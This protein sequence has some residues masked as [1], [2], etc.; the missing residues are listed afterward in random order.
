[1][2]TGRIHM[3]AIRTSILLIILAVGCF[4]GSSLLAEEP[5]L[6]ISADDDGLAWGTCPDFMPDG[7]AIAVLHGDPGAANADVF[8]KV[9]G[10]SQ[11]PLHRHTSAERMVLVSGQMNVT[12]E[13]QDAVTIRAGDYAFGPPGTPHSARCV[14]G[15]PA[16]C[17]LH[18][19]TR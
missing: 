10:G 6:V 1:M 4:S 2:K 7:C 5:P 17:S 19:S 18:S 11:I 16:F 8:F 3:M 13:G 12:Y 14:P 15:R 9:P